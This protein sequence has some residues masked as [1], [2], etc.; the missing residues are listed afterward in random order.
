MIFSPLNLS[1]AVPD[2]D[3]M[4]VANPGLN[5][6]WTRAYSDIG[7][8]EPAA[9]TG[10]LLMADPELLELGWRIQT[11]L[12]SSYMALEMIFC[13]SDGGIKLSLLKKTKITL[14]SVYR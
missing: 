11:S 10:R 5:P 1:A 7:L 12:S 8:L 6:D 14:M 2:P 13:L 9:D 3:T 4:P